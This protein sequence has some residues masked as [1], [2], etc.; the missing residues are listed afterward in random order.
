M[1][2]RV[3]YRPDIDGLRA[4]AV[5]SVLF[6]HADLSFP[7]GYVGV[8]VF[9]VISGYLITR[10][11]VGDLER[12]RFTFKNFW[13]RRLR[14]IWPAASVTTLATLALGAV[15][16]D[17]EA[18]RT[19]GG[20]AIAQTLMLANVRFMSSTDYFAVSAD[21]RSL[22][23]T[24]SLA[25]EEQFYLVHPFV[26]VF[27]WRLKARL[28]RP[29]FVLFAIASLVLSVVALDRY[30]LATFYLLPTRA[31]ELLL[32]GILALSPGWIVRSSRVG[33]GVAIAGLVLVMTPMFAYAR[34]TPFPGLAAVPPC[35]GTAMLILA[36][37]GNSNRLSAC[38]AWEPMRRIGLIS[39]SLYL[40]HWPLLAM[41]RSLTAPE[42]PSLA[43]RVAVLPVSFV[44][45]YLSWRFVENRFRNAG[46]LPNYGRVVLGSVA[47]TVL[48]LTIGAAVR[49]SDG[50]RGRFSEEVLAHIDPV[51]VERKWQNTTTA[52]TDASSLVEPIGAVGPEPC[53]V[54]WGD[55]HGLAISTVIDRL[56]RER[57][58]AGVARLRPATTPVPGLWSQRGG[59]DAA[60]ANERV[61]GWIRERGVAHVVFAARWTVQVDGQPGG[62]HDAR[63]LNLVAPIGSAP[64]GLARR[65]ESAGALAEA[66]GALAR[67]LEP[68]GITLWILLE[69]PR[70]GDT[71]QSRGMRAHLTG[72]S[73]PT[74]GISREQHEEQSRNATR[75]I[76]SVVGTN[77]RVVDLADGFFPGDGGGSVTSGPGG[78]SYYAD[79]D[80]V[81]RIGAEALLAGVIA[82]IMDEVAGSDDAERGDPGG[83]LAP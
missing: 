68:D 10:L 21:L 23:H 40:V 3:G 81:N 35:L 79:D 7:G 63:A 73:V 29:A 24:W 46:P 38:L 4:V 19:L 28:L 15:L 20:D 48:I 71:P 76:R 43:A 39:Y 17:P 49:V 78:V 60:K 65:F 55:S 54:L 37:T 74:R 64:P 56:A 12:G 31:W 6:F 45:A 66:L 2:Q 58:I 52:A 32:G 9:F 13:A 47:V 69:V 42:E 70:Q 72:Q 14:R 80:H 26:V 75:A 27:L 25:V 11:I 41:M 59:Q 30:P 33:A 50:W 34:T 16:L 51:R 5:L 18:Y 44:L 67:E 61:L 57:S 53:F 8:D 77:V 62:A 83:D 1:S 36:G 82:S 22:L